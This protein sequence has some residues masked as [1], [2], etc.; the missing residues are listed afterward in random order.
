MVCMN[1]EMENEDK[2]SYKQ[3]PTAKNCSKWIA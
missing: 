3:L 1:K 2:Y